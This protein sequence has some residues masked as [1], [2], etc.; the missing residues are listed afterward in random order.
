[1]T[2]KKKAGKLASKELASFK[3]KARSLIR[4]ELGPVTISDKPLK[5]ATHRF[6][7]EV[8]EFRSLVIDISIK[9]VISAPT[10]QFIVRPVI[11]P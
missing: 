2:A 1:M 5:K 6:T 4:K 9:P 3:A 11:D 8:D 10:L 7:Y